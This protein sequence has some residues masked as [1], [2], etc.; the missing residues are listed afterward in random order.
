MVWLATREI[1]GASE[2]APL[3]GRRLWNGPGRIPQVGKNS[4]ESAIRSIA[5]QQRKIVRGLFYHEMTGADV[6]RALGISAPTVSQGKFISLSKI[7]SLL[8]SDPNVASY[9]IGGFKNFK[10]LE[11]TSDEEI[12][13][14]ICDRL[15][16]SALSPTTFTLAKRAGRSR[17]S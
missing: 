13:D 6:G 10:P 4:I 17:S 3:S 14:L 9:L 11:R 2:E 15:F 1:E 12:S 16:T 8:N 7:R 5:L